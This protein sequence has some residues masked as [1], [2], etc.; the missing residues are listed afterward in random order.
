MKKEQ[1]YEPVRKWLASKGFRALVTHGRGELVLMLGPLL[2]GEVLE[3]DV[4]G[5]RRIE[6]LEESVVVE[7]EDDP[8]GIMEAL[9][10]CAIF[11]TY[12]NFVYLVLP[13]ELA[14][15]IRDPSLLQQLKVGLLV[16]SGLRKK[17]NEVVKAKKTTPSADFTAEFTRLLKRALA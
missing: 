4:A 2:G 9:G 3:P 6:Y 15:G 14:E 1:L 13:D 8:K 11:K 7:A 12:S 5:L 10:R 16:V 17:V